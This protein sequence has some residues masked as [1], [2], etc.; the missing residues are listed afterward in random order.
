VVSRI[1]NRIRPDDGDPRHGTLGGYT[2]HHCR[3]VDCTEANT[4]YYVEDYRPRIRAAGLPDGDERHGSY[5]AYTN[6]QCRCVDCRAAHAEY[7]RDY[8][9]RSKA[10][11]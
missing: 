9:Q 6:Y 8:H 2:N 10:A 3:C 4:R 7:A 11:P 1:V 5:N